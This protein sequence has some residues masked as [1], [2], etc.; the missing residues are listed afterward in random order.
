[1]S[2]F[3]H[4]HL[5][6]EYSLLD[7]ACRIKDIP[8]RAKEC[9]HDAVA[10]TD[11]G[12]MFG[13]VEFFLEC[14]KN[15]IKPIIGCEVYVAP[16]SRFDKSA[17]YSLSSDI[18]EH[19]KSTAAHLVLLCKN[20]IGYRN[21]CELVSMGYTEGFY[22]KPRVDMELL[23]EYSEGLICL[24]ACLSGRIPR[25]LLEGDYDAAKSV[26]L[27]FSEI[28]GKDNFFIEIQY[29]GLDDQ[30]RI[31]PMLVK[32]ADECGLPL[33]A[34]N[35]CHYLTRA[36]AATQAALM[37]IQTNSV[38]GEGA[39]VGFETDEFY[40]KTTDE[41]R[42]LFG[43]YNGAMENTAKISERCNFEFEFDKT[44]LPRFRCPN[45]EDPST[46]LKKLAFEGLELRIQSSVPNTS[47]AVDLDTYTVDDYK[48]RLEYELDVIS[49]M[50]YSEYFLIVADYVEFARSKGIP[51]GPGRGSGAGSLVAFCL[52]IT[53][54]DPLSFDLLF[55]RFLN[56]ERVSMPD[57]DMDFCYNRR[58]EVIDYV[59][60]KYGR[61]HVSQII[62]FGTL[63]AK[64]S[65]RDVGR[66]LGY[67]YADVDACAV[68][69]PKGLNV[70]LA[71]A[72]ASK[73]FRQLYDSSPKI[74]RLVDI[75][76]KLEGMPRN[77]STH[78][79]GVVIT[80]KPVTDYVPVAT[81][82]GVVVTQYDMDTVSHLG[83]LKFDF[84]ALRY[85]TIIEDT[86]AEIR[87]KNPEFKIEGISL[88][89]KLTFKLISKGNTMG[90]FQLESSGIRQMLTNLKP[91][92]LD[93]LI[94][95]ISL[96]RP[97]P[98]DSIP[99]Y[100]ERRHDNSKIKYDIPELEPI[101]RSTYGCVVYQEQVL[102]IL[103][104]LGGFTYGHA[105]LVRRA[106]SKKKADLIEAER[107]SFLAGTDRKGIER[108][109]AEKLFED[110]TAFANYA[111]NKSHAAA[112][113]VISYRTAY[114]KAHYP[115]EY[116]A[117]LMT[118]VL[119]NLSKLAEYIEE[120][121]KFAINVLPPDIN[122][123]S[124]YFHT[125]SEGNIL[126]GLLAIKNTGRQAIEAIICERQ[127][128]RFKSFE[129]F[130]CRMMPS[131]LLNKRL[132]EA[133]IKAGAFDSLGVYRSR[134]IA[135]YEKILELE[136][137][138]RRSNSDGQI[139]MFT[140]FIVAAEETQNEYSYPDIP[141]Y[142]LRELLLL[143][144]EAAG[145]YLSG[146]M[147]DNY[148]KHV[149]ALNASRIA[150]VI[151]RYSDE[152]QISAHKT[153]CIVGVITSVSLKN[154]KKNEK[155]AFI[156]IADR[157]GEIE[158]IIFPAVFNHFSDLIYRDA[159]IYVEGT[160]SI[161]EDEDAKILINHIRKLQNNNEFVPLTRIENSATSQSQPQQKTNTVISSP[162]ER[163]FAKL[164]QTGEPI[165]IYLRVPSMQS[166]EFKRADN[167][168]EIFCGAV[169]L[170]Y[171]D[172]EKHA[173][174][175]KNVGI[176]LSDTVL[177]ELIDCLGADN[178]VV[179]YK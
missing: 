61:N 119:G 166:E 176:S 68:K 142:P 22:S 31:L 3:V 120:C 143:E 108:S 163:S 42:M 6:S 4:L 73:D 177:A 136:A 43:K 37:C 111:Y 53:D 25:L 112:Y 164:D 91:E 56:P 99:Q 178:V 77:V 168:A 18:A 127:K 134:L 81:S 90:V 145:M 50:G 80:D 29:H 84:L 62:T 71:D 171:F 54:I 26:A 51:V 11:H 114:L 78:A 23:K 67:A 174:I 179:K 14:K 149:S 57:I 7:G 55:E 46:Y 2:E 131:G 33:V 48:Q 85:L 8:I 60:R 34:T 16:G 17:A 75:A 173:Y 140:N 116:Y 115:R 121:K 88:L 118:S 72:M 141:E 12:A 63:A 146:H 153:E 79:A 44:V 137:D 123:S 21:L 156:S 133:L 103:R 28:Y 151:S 125:S 124:V 66:A 130:V 30:K 97:G 45:D 15:G 32:L 109:K 138:K 41:M 101:L 157:S 82:S 158:C 95:A 9:G 86:C 58:Q 129:D 65:I 172:N 59:S 94:A 38:L 148:S 161:R 150:D 154:T 19:K 69:V 70:T 1:M 122:E 102:K 144:K 135:S 107:E 126:Y 175:K 74:Q 110:I 139:D 47:C 169:P 155:M 35:D 132:V 128:S 76:I 24:S 152:D 170:C 105:D 92:S 52:Q 113:A 93:D 96:Y 36:D 49:D 27:E 87:E 98:M 106:M 89:D 5:H 117:A 167:L 20:E 83:L 13:V 100:I 159:A 64:A 40:Y 10:L 104:E 147:I 39:N 162:A 165:V 160:P